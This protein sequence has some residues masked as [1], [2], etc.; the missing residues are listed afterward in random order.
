MSVIFSESDKYFNA[1]ELDPKSKEILEAS[2]AQ[3]K[4][5][6]EHLKDLKGEVR[7]KYKIEVILPPR[8]KKNEAIACAVTAFK[9]GGNIHGGGDELLYLCRNENDAKIGCGAVLKSNPMVGTI[10]GGVV[11]VFY[12]DNCKKYV[13]R[14]LLSSTFLYKLPLKKLAENIYGLF[15]KLDS[16]ADIYLKHVHVDVRDAASRGGDKMMQVPQRMEYAIYTL[17]NIFK[18]T[19]NDSQV[20]RKIEGFLTA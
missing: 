18:D 16:N 9:S 3:D 8:R 12:C 15:R 17:K 4:V 19:A 1:D 10:D 11:T 7:A 2:R 13:N 5:P 6:E 20:L 14:E